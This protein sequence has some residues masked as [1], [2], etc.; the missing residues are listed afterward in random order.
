MEEKEI[1]KIKRLA[2]KFT[3]LN[4]LVAISFAG[5]IYFAG[6]NTGGGVVREFN[7]LFMGLSIVAAFVFFV[8][9]MIFRKMFLSLK[10][11]WMI[12][13]AFIAF[14]IIMTLI[15]KIIIFN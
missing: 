10:K 3:P 12:E 6:V 15:I 4:L 9:D 1:Q 7:G 8:S 11:I 5:A 2:I 14:A 13:T